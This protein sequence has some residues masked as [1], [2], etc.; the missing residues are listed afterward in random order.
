[1]LC[2]T[3]IRAPPPM[4]AARIGTSASTQTGNGSVFSGRATQI[5]QGQLSRST[6]AFQFG[7]EPR[8]GEDSRTEEQ[9]S[10]EVDERQRISLAEP[11]FLA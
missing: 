5:L 2:V 7:G 11:I 6:E 8:H 10:I 3:R 9:R 4:A 1:M